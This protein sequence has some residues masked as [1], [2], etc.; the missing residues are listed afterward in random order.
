[1]SCLWRPNRLRG[2]VQQLGHSAPVLL[3]APARGL[4]RGENRDP[5]HPTPGRSPFQSK[6]APNLVA[7]SPVPKA[8]P[9]KGPLILICL[10]FFLFIPCLLHLFQ[11][12]GQSDDSSPKPRLTQTRQL[13]NPLQHRAARY[14]FGVHIPK[15]SGWPA[16]TSWGSPILHILL[17]TPLSLSRKP[18][19]S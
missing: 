4:G 13:P 3:K 12:N 14:E 5:P 6:D 15:R 16:G 19:H 8:C 18:P 7:V 9:S 10:F 1:M 17:Q 2:T 11:G